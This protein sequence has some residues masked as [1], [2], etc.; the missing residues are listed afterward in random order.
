MTHGTPRVIAVCRS[1]G[2]VPKLPMDEAQVVVDGIVGDLHAHAKH[3]RPDRAL[4]LLDL[5]VLEELVAE[6]F[7]LAPGVAGEN[8][9]L[10]GLHVQKL[11]PG[12]LLAIGDVVVRLEQPRKPCYVLD[13]IHPQLKEATVGRCGFMASVVRGGTI[14]PGMD[15]QVL[16]DDPADKSAEPTNSAE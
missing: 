9:T 2:G 13:A 14:R 8:L 5:E 10:A 11:A 4:S 6:G 12:T 16:S 3:N 7:A 1:A 15:I